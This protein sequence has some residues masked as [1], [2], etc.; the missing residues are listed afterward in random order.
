MST[1]AIVEKTEKSFVD[2]LLDAVEGAA[3]IA[4]EYAGKAAWHLV[5]PLDQV[6]KHT[7]E[8][9]MESFNKHFGNGK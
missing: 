7:T 8:P 5:K 4:G 9:F 1:E 2:S 3:V 6:H